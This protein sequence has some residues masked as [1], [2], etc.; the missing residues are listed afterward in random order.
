M[1]SIRRRLV[2]RKKHLDGDYKPPECITDLK[3]SKLNKDPCAMSSG[4]YTYFDVSV[5]LFNLSIIR[6]KLLT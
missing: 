5:S 3:I 6:E 1:Q 4:T 2:R